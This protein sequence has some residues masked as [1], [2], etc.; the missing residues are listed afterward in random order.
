MSRRFAFV[1]VS[2]TAIA[3]FLVGL[4]VATSWVRQS[5]P[6]TPQRPTRAVLAAVSVTGRTASGVNFADIA[7]RL[8]PAVVNIDATS[9]TRTRDLPSGHPTLPG[10][11]PLV[12]P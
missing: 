11:G 5:S 6:S 1:T 7:E 4:V 12:N 8:N 2:L 9:R 3:A 10:D